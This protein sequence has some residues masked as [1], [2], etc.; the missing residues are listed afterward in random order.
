MVLTKAKSI[1]EIRK[2]IAEQKKRDEHDKISDYLNT[3]LSDNKKNNDAWIY[4]TNFYKQIGKLDKAWELIEEAKKHL[5]EDTLVEKWHNFIY[6][7][8]RKDAT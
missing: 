7:T 1:S 6:Q 8:I 5:P 2:E 4:T 3:Y